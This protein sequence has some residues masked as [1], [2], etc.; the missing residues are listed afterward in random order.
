MFFTL[1]KTLQDVFVATDE[2]GRVL[3]WPTLEKAKQYFEGAYRRK[4]GQSHEGAMSAAIH[5][6]QFQ[7]AI[8]ECAIDELRP[9]IDYKPDQQGRLCIG[10]REYHSLAG[11]MPGLPCRKAAALARWETGIHPALAKRVRA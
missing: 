2:T 4:Q 10:V 1:I 8:I 6:I 7:P 11:K 5:W 3:A 9:L